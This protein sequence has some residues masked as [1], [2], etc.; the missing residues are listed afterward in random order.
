MNE[1]EVSVV[2]PCF[3]EERTIGLCIEKVR[4][5]FLKENINGEIIVSDNGSIDRSAAIAESMG[6]KIARQPVRGYGAAYLKGLAQA[7]G[8]YIVIADS[9]GT[10]D[11][12]D[13][14][15]FLAPLKNGYDFVMGSRFKGRINRNAMPWLNRYIGNPVLSG[16]CRLFF[17][18]ALSDIHC[19][20]R[21]FTRD[22]YQKMALTTRGMEF[23]TEMVVS[24]LSENLKIMEIPISYS[25]RIGESKLKPLSDAWRHV[26]FMLIYCPTWLYLIPGLSGVSFS[27]SFLVFS[28]RH[29]ISFFGHYWDVHAV[30]LAGALCILSY[31]VL[32]LGV[33]AQSFA[34][35]V[36]LI[37]NNKFFGIFNRYYKLEA[38]IFIGAVIFLCG[39][40]ISLSVLLEWLRSHFGPLDRIKESV[41]GTTLIIIGLQTVS[42]SFFLSMLLTGRARE[43][44]CL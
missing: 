29:P 31:Q 16:I 5:A 37:K 14:P 9:D 6:A 8:K 11:F 20:M 24:A 4:Q 1:I 12:A 30:I 22:A 42:F 28:L 25:Y 44:S 36:N 39:F 2:M 7:R 41:L 33:C 35:R 3:N 23:A 43:R 13:I 17:R 27:L 18:T 34:Y 15:R 32:A 10:Y 40:F 21:S 38:G 26:R 19:G